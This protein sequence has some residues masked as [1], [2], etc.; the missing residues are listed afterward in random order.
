MF[1]LWNKYK[2]K[3]YQGHGIDPDEIFLDSANLMNF[4]TDQFEGRIDRPISK[5]TLSFLYLCF[6]LIFCGLIYK[7]FLLQVVQ[8]EENYHLSENNRLRETV[9]FATRGNVYD[10]NGVPII[11]NEPQAEGSDFAKRVYYENEGLSGLLGFITY[12]KKDSKGFY[13]E[14]NYSGREGIEKQFEDVIGG[15]NGSRITETNALG[16]VISEN[17]VHNPNPGDTLNLSIDSRVQEQLYKSIKEIAEQVNFQGGGGIIMDIHTGEVIAMAS[18]PEYNS[19]KLA[20]GDPEYIKQVSADSKK[21]FL[22][23]ITQGLYTPGS[24]VKPYMA[25]GAL[26]EGVIDQYTN[27]ISTG[28]LEV[29]NP[30][31]PD[32]PTFFSDWKAHGAVDARR[33]LAVSSNIYFYVVGGGFKDINGLGITKIESYM[34]QFGFGSSVTG[35]I[36]SQYTG[37][38]PN[39]EWKAKNFD[40]DIWRLGDTYFTSIGQYGFQVTP[41]QVIRAV[42]ALANKGTVI[43]PVIVKDTPVDVVSKVENIK[44]EI[45]DIIHEGMRMGVTEGTAKGLNMDA[46]HIAAKTGTAELGVSKDNVNSW[47]TGFFPYE[48]PRYAFVIVM[49]KGNRHNVIG[50]VAVSRKLFDWMA[51]YTP[52]YFK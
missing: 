44:P 35:Q 8:G 11:W 45:W 9:I 3:K 52:E 33:A 24:I 2:Y 20:D 14:L 4:D 40:N 38:I 10:R 34:R 32:N 36:S 49:E 50:G 12:P 16:D 51:I 23:R 43:N 46:V 48:N 15:V 37:T 17:L 47:T 6:L 13:Y 25:I 42:A 7:V 26:N 31:N 19:Q 5:S 29:P 41:L 30:Y 1:R 18:Y 22:N 39:P 27:I 21:P 28:K